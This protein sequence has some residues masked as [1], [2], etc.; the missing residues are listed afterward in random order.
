MSATSKR[1]RLKLS[2]V[3]GDGPGPGVCGARCG[4]SRTDATRASPR[5]PGTGSTSSE[6]GTVWQPVL[7]SPVLRV[8]IR[9]VAVHV[10]LRRKGVRLGGRHQTILPFF[11][12]AFFDFNFSSRA[13]C[14]SKT[15]PC[16]RC[17]DLHVGS[18]LAL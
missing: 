2:C 11:A 10:G 4:R 9:A 3:L 8:A 17:D 14:S 16:S 7:E 5:L 18:D 6:T 13:A 1:H 12:W 15:S